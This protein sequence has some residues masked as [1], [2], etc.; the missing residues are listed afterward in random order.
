MSASYQ[1]VGQ[2]VAAL[3]ELEVMLMV[4]VLVIV[5]IVNAI[6]HGEWHMQTG[7]RRAGVHGAHSAMQ[8]ASDLC[9]VRGAPKTPVLLCAGMPYTG[10]KGEFE[11]V[12]FTTLTY[13][14]VLVGTYGASKPL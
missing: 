5:V 12:G 8:A 13:V 1:A 9:K 7:A 2:C 4:Q 6:T 11:V 14:L 10:V 3:S